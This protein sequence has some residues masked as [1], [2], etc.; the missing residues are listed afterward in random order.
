[1]AKETPAG[2]AQGGADVTAG[3]HLTLAEVPLPK[4]KGPAAE[5]VVKGSG[6]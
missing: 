1:M 4:V 6:M 3:A 2:E 5:A